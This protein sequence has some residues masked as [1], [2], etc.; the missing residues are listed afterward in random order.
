MVTESDVE[1]GFYTTNITGNRAVREAS[2]QSGTGIGITGHNNRLILNNIQGEFEL[3]LFGHSH[4]V[5]VRSDQ[6]VTLQVYVHDGH[7]HYVEGAETI[8]IQKQDGRINID[9]GSW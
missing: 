6:S 1:A 3:H 8:N 2:P 4:D 9:E 5:E 7:S